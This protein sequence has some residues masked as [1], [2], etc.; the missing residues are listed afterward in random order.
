MTLLQAAEKIAL[1]RA[2]IEKKMVGQETLVS[3]ALISLV[4]GGHVLV[5]GAPGLGKTLLVR[6]IAAALGGTSARV[7][8][9]PDLMPSDITGNVLFDARA[10]DFIM[11]EGPVFTNILI[12]DEIN[13]A[14]AKTQAALFEAMQEGQVSLDGKTRALPRPFMVLATENP[15]EHEGTYPL[16]DAQK[17]RFLLKVI[18][19]YP[20][21]DEEGAMLSRVLADD[22]GGAALSVAGVGAVT[23]PSE[24]AEVQACARSVVIAPRVLDYALRLVRATRDNPNAQYGAGPRGGLALLRA[25]RARALIAGRDFTLPDDVKALA[26]PA[27][28][29][30]VALTAESEFTGGTAEKVIEDVIARTEAPRT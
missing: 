12:A 24:F 1:I 29:H 26:V 3:L 30:R 9:T 19:D 6:C 15:L 18:V 7:Q 11:R 16:P 25:A 27:L 14:P 2:E 13:R 4:A 22:D 8:F 21:F 17:D 28:A 23:S 5:E 10:L 20:A